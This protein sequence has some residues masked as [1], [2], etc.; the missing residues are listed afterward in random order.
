MAPA[1][2]WPPGSAPG[3]AGTAS[4]CRAALSLGTPPAS[5]GSLLSLGPTPPSASAQH[6]LLKRPQAVPPRTCC[7]RRASALT[8]CR[9][10]ASPSLAVS[11]HSSCMWGSL[12]P[13]E[14][15]SSQTS[16][17]YTFQAAASTLAPFCLLSIHYLSSKATE[18]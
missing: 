1:P 4:R 5:R 18:T 13:R 14:V 17:S 9:T 10:K 2:R 6:A 3:T 12:V 15:P 8:G 16:S 7:A 11:L